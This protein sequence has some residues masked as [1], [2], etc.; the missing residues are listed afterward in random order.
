MDDYR[1]IRT[2]WA[3]CELLPYCATFA[4]STNIGS[5]AAI[6]DYDQR[7]S[8]ILKG[9]HPLFLLRIILFLN[10]FRQSVSYHEFR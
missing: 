2:E 8:R 4:D 7:T 1:V 5:M 9:E 6:R 10:Q 3:A